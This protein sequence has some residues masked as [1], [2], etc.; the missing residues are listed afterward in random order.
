MCG[1]PNNNLTK[2]LCHR[3]S[4]THSVRKKTRMFAGKF[5]KNYFKN[6]LNFPG[7][8]VVSV[9]T[10]NVFFASRMWF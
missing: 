9:D 2:Y 3:A 6:L 7:K 5:G 10:L 4:E 8:S 1:N